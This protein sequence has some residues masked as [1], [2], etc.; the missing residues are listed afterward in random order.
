MSDYAD[1]LHQARWDRDLSVRAAAQQAG[2]AASSWSAYEND[3]RAP[4]TATKG[5]LD[6]W[7]AQSPQPFPPHRVDAALDVLDRYV[8][9]LDTERL[10]RLRRIAQ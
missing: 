2:V 1:R 3:R 6:A 7:L 4:S 9:L 8:P 5:A 10:A